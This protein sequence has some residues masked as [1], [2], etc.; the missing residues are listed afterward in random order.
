MAVVTIAAM[1]GSGVP[2]QALPA[3]VTPAV[4]PQ[5]DPGPA[6]KNVRTAPLRFASPADNPAG[7]DFTPTATRWPAAATASLTLGAST[8]RSAGDGKARAVGVPVWVQAQAGYAGPSRFDV[9]V[10]DRATA[11]KAGINGVVLTLTPLAAERSDT[12]T[13]RVGVDYSAF[14][15]A[16]GGNYGSRL[17]LVQLPACIL[18]TPELPKCRRPSPLI[19]TNDAA[20]KS[21]S[22]EVRVSGTSA[23]PMILAASASAGED[24]G[25][26]GTYSAT[27]LGPSASWTGGGSTGSFGYTYPITVP[28]G[29]S[30]LT[31]QLVLSYDSSSVD[32]RTASTSAQSSWVGEGWST[33]QSFIEQSFTSCSDDPGGEASPKKT[34]DQCYNGPILTLSLNGSS[35]SLVWDKINEVWKPQSDTG[36]VIAHVTNSGNNSGTYNTDYW[37]VTE[38]NGTEY[39]FGRNRLPGWTSGKLETKSVDYMPVYSAHDGDPCYDSA[40][41]S[42]SVCTMAYRWNLDYVKDVH[43]NAM[44]YYYQQKMNYYGQNQ[45]ASNGKYVRES[46]LDRIDFGFTD[47]NAYS[48]VPNQVKFDVSDRCVSGT[49]QPL[50]ATNK[51]NWPDLPYDLICGASDTCS[52]WSPAFFST[53]RLTSI[54]T[55]QYSTTASGYLAVDSYSLAHTMPSTGD[56]TSPTLWLASVA[57]TGLGVA[58]SGVPTPAVTLPSVTFTSI[59]LQ[60]R[61]D[62]TPDGLAPFYKHRIHKIKTETGSEITVTYDRP[63][64]CNASAKPTPATNTK[65]CYPVRWTPDGYAQP[66]TD[67]F[68]KY[69]VIRVYATDPTGGS[70]G[71]T[72]S[73][74]YSGGAAWHYDTNEL[75]KKKHRSYGQ[76]RGYGKVTTLTG[77][78]ANDRRTATENVFYRGMSKNNSATVVNLVDS[79][80]GKH[81]DHDELAGRGLETTQFLGEGG[82]IDN[83]TITSYWVSAATAT[84]TRAD[85][86]ALTS[87]LAAPVQT[88]TRQAVTSTE[89]VSWRYTQADNSY[90]ASISSPTF[91]LLKHTYSHT[92]P[93]VAAYDKC[94]TNTYAGANPQK[95]LIGLIAEVDVV[96][97]ACGGFAPAT[98][99]TELSAAALNALIAPSSVS[100]PAEVISN[101]LTYYDDY[102]WATAFPQPAVPAK[103]NV[104]MVRKATGYVGS[105]YQYRTESRAKYDSVG[106]VKEAYDAA[107]NLTEN[108]YSTNAVGLVTSTSVDPPLH[109]AS[110]TVLDTQRGL[111]LTTTDVNGVVTVQQYDALGRSKKVW[112]HS[113]PTAAPANYEFDYDVSN[114]SWTTTTTRKLNE[115]SNYQVSTVIYDS[116]FR[117]R[118]TQTMTPQ[119]GRM[120]IDTIYDTRGWVK[121]RNNGWWNSTTTPSNV[122]VMPGDV[123]VADRPMPSQTFYSHDGLG[124]IV[125]ERA[126]NSDIVVSTTT[127]VYNGDRTTVIPP[128]GG[129]VK[130]TIT[131]P[132]GRKKQ[133]LEYKSGPTLNAPGDEFAGIFRIS[134][135]STTTATFGYDPRGNQSSIAFGSRNW[136]TT[137][138]L[139]GQVLTKT[140]PDTGTTDNMK[141]DPNGNLLESRDARGLTTSFAYDVLNRKIGKYAGPASGQS[142]SNKLAEW[143]Y[144]NSDGA[145]PGM[146]FAFGQVTATIAYWGNSAYRVQQKNFNVFG[147][148]RGVTVTIPSAE[149]AALGKS[150]TVNYG[151]TPVTGLLSSET[152]PSAVAGLPIETVNHGYSTALD[153]PTALGGLAGYSQNVSYDAW[154]RVGQQVIG[155]TPDT[156]T[157]TST[158]DTHTGRP[159]LQHLKR[160]NTTPGVDG[161]DVLDQFEYTYDLAGNIQR[162]VNTRNG[163]PAQTE[164]ECF[165]YD[166]LRRLTDGWTA[167]DNCAVQ[168][169]SA[170][171]A[172]VVSNLGASS[173]YWTHWAIDD[174]GNR[175][176]ETQYGVSPAADVTVSYA[177]G[178]GGSRP[179]TLT[180]TTGGAGGN[181][182]YSYHPDGSMK[183]RNADQGA[184]S[185]TWNESGQLTAVAGG[186][187]GT[188]N[189]IYDASGNLLLQKDPGLT[190][191][192]LP[193]QEITLNTATGALSG[194]RY[195]A[196]PGGGTCI[197][198]GAGS[199]Y[200]FAVVDHHGT[201]RLYLNNSAQSATWRQTSSYGGN[202]GASVVL[203]NSHGFLDKV[204]N[205]NTGLVQIGAR[206]YDAVT[207]RFISRDPIFDAEN[208]QTWNGY[209]YSNNNPLGFSDSSGLVMCGDDRCQVTATTT[210]S[211]KTKVRDNRRAV[212]QG[213]NAACAKQRLLSQYN[214][215]WQLNWN[216][217][218]DVIRAFACVN[219]QTCGGAV[220]S[221]YTSITPGDWI[222]PGLVE[223]LRLTNTANL[224]PRDR[225]IPGVY[226]EEYAGTTESLEA[227]LE[228]PLGK[229]GAG[230]SVSY[231]KE[232]GEGRNDGFSFPAMSDGIYSDAYVAP[233]IA[234]QWVETKSVIT[235]SDGRVV[236]ELGYDLNVKIY[237]YGRGK[238]AGG[239]NNLPTIA[240]TEGILGDPYTAIFG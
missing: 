84:R 137:Y 232:W 193:G 68:N 113:R 50:N 106:R 8:N 128:L 122:L 104:T 57:R 17:R 53:V 191:L 9:R 105:A 114:S 24:G 69:A 144:D 33:P 10:T 43:G 234:Y 167:N 29:P 110:V 130:T 131:D 201:P 163:A 117:E 1:L 115:S 73:Y 32:G 194:A 39:S 85:L 239:F 148:S 183:T 14:A 215:A 100:R 216:A 97:K 224:D 25:D 202:R 135:G 188:S 212:N 13:V 235:Y 63:D 59:N 180:G 6:V 169:V 176:S 151:Y 230:I 42:A 229:S 2:A 208:S 147:K 90:D 71:L 227:A 96:A 76:Y 174:N 140:D 12:G 107:G 238:A 177:Y 123:P 233:K 64:P 48:T 45:G 79:A 126:A 7:R 31:P 46:Y 102:G 161:D 99:A 189:F 139:L 231:S 70:A 93:A 213:C 44:A 198:K 237:G 78:V 205:A 200:S 219:Y 138:N 35:S 184:Q 158:Y 67:W 109:P 18:Q 195:Y 111:A 168:P 30:S 52:S 108:I 143:V 27:D 210:P 166:G 121:Q 218:P 171:R 37:T 98:P 175:T 49:C 101:T 133:V 88:Y 160:D 54:V 162:T 129:V 185:F 197:R 150:Y 214:K 34:S 190:V 155:S 217:K 118:Q 207:G 172:M 145:V 5:A 20:A 28:S 204:A 89:P 3:P 81:E 124:R 192:Y 66:I 80:G 83:S 178:S 94:V 41:F 19:S 153:L 74:L 4:V 62:S 156:A 152:Y 199:S 220:S 86:P 223:R 95:N 91:G 103:G 55:K 38:R 11:D 179:D 173:R 157:L 182:S 75:V 15:Q 240:T 125:R 181:T 116:I 164:T 112:L 203:P 236:T 127:T 211:G 72:T 187:D 132:L 119:G 165:R 141:Y 58:T 170:S 61:L 60:N 87:R 26:A 21:V 65:S 154:G 47:A 23:Q 92:V 146:T 120:I 56:S 209:A 196:L 16:F 77:D 142:T 22:A 134:G 36:S 226:V 206:L 228:I 186:T 82:T 136:S 225:E 149:G 159:L 222:D 221:V 40:G 51:A